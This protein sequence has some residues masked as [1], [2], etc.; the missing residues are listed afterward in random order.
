MQSRRLF[1]Y[2][3][4]LI[5]TTRES[6]IL[7]YGR[8]KPPDF[9]TH[10][11]NSWPF[12]EVGHDPEDLYLQLHNKYNTTWP[13]P[14]L[15]T[16]FHLLMAER[17]MCRFEEISK[18]IEDIISRLWAQPS[19]LPML[20]HGDLWAAVAC[21]SRHQS[22]DELA[23]LL[24][25]FYCERVTDSGRNH[26]RRVAHKDHATPRDRTTRARRFPTFTLDKRANQNPGASRS[27]KA[28]KPT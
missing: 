9:E 8:P 14:P 12:W 2:T 22:V 19:L 21:L 6:S 1:L 27:A 10:S 5:H 26:G 23:L 20:P 28:G 25:Q 16:E 13:M 17:Q 3:I 7:E 15:P 11:G 4:G 24:G 18:A